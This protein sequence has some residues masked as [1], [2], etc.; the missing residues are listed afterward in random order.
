MFDAFSPAIWIHVVT[1][2]VALAAGTA[3]FPLPK[4]TRLHR[5]LG[6]IYVVAMI[7]TVISAGMAPATTMRFGDT[8]FGFFHVFVAVGTISMALSLAA[9][10]RWRRTRSVKALRAHQYHLS[11][12]YAG[13]LMAG[14]SQLAVNP[15]FS[16]AQTMSQ[17]EYWL[18]FS[19]INVSIYVVAIWLIQT[20]I[21]RH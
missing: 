21:A 2:V 17:G 18:W 9:I 10:L 4:G 3:I 20:R 14:F 19:L 8:R 12:S 1:V 15:R 16:P 13:L 6:R 7:A 5:T 11:Y